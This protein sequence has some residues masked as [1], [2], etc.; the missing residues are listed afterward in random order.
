MRGVIPI[1]ARW[2]ALPAV[3]LLCAAG[4]NALRPKPLPWR[5]DWS[6]HIEERARSAGLGLATVHQVRAAVSAGEALLV[7]ARE[8]ERFRAGR[9][10]GAVSLPLA[11]AREQ[12]MT[13]PIADDPDQPM[14]AYCG[15]LDCEDAL[16]LALLL[17]RFGY[18]QVS[19]FA[20]G[21]AEWQAAGGAAEA[22]P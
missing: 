14:I 16:E 19:L 8:A 6:A 7:D 22:G 3:A 11:T 1:G 5:A 12:L 15:G 21:W 2:L 4:V 13:A 20:G 18:R 10:P 17:R 9:I